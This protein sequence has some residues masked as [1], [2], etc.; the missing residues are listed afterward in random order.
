MQSPA[1]L[2]EWVLTR[3]ASR[4]LRP[5]AHEGRRPMMNLRVAE[6]RGRR[7]RG[8]VVSAVL[9]AGPAR[10]ARGTQAPAPV[11]ARPR[12]ADRPDDPAR[13]RRDVGHRGAGTGDG[14]PRPPAPASPRRWRASCRGRCAEGQRVAKGAVLFRLD[15][16]VADVAVAKARQALQFAEQAFERQKEARVRARPRRRGCTRRPSRTSS[17]RATSWRTPRRSARCSTSGRR[18]PARS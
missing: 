4:Q 16:R 17:P 6:W 13:V 12:R 9:R 14:P 15:S 8:V 2:P 11:V 5:P 3:L 18:S 1:D 10:P 7:P